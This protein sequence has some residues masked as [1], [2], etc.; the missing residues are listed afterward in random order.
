MLTD[1]KPFS[2]EVDQILAGRSAGPIPTAARRQAG[3][4][5]GARSD[6]PAG[7]GPRASQ[8]LRQARFGSGRGHRALAGRRCRHGL[9]RS[10]ARS[11]RPL[12]SPPPAVRGRV[13]RRGCWSLIVALAMAV[14]LLSLA[15]SNES[16]ARRNEQKL[17]NSGH[18]KSRGSPRAAK[19]G[20]P[21][22]GN[23]PQRASGCA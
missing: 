23:R 20:R 13:R 11:L 12:G 8:A 5:Q 21:A 3:G 14:P 22:L 15:W 9:E 6:L 18:A 1:Q 7:D 4:A 2:G 10:L 17:A 19:G 16:A